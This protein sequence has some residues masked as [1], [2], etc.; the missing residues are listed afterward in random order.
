MRGL[1]G[2]SENQQREL[3]FVSILSNKHDPWRRQGET[4][5]MTLLDG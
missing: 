3:Q 4:E 5:V 2:V 1:Q